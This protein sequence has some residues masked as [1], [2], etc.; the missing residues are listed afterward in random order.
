[1]AKKQ[2]DTELDREWIGKLVK[3]PLEQRKLELKHCD[4]HSLAKALSDYPNWQSE[5]IAEALQ[6]PLSQEFI[7][8][9]KIYKGE[10]PFPKKVRKR[11]HVLNKSRLATSIFLVVLLIVLIFVLNVLFPS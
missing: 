7:K 9:V 8:A 4:L 11:I 6:K 5:K 3:M 1:M 10:L 2:F